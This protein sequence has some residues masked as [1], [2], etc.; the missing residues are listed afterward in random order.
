MRRRTFFIMFVAAVLAAVVFVSTGSAA[1]PPPTIVTGQDAGWPDVRGW[2]ALGGA[3]RQFAPWGEWP[4]AFSP[5][6]TYQQGIRV[7]VGDVNGDGHQEII[8]APGR[9][10]FTELRVFDGRTFDQVGSLLPFKD[11]A[12]WA[13]AYV[14][15]GDTNGDGRAEIVEGLDSGCC[16]TL[17][18]LDGKSGDDLSGF[19]PYGDR[20]E[21]G[22][23]VASGDV[24]GDGKTELFAVAY[25]VTV[26]LTDGRGRTSIARSMA[27]VVRKR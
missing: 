16:T 14:A 13:G 23:R 22:A 7:A 8:T 6:A 27:I 25:A 24:N 5:Y 11:G 19:F 10:A 21:V 2:N 9:N 12:W 3:A 1:P 17:H 15:T 4:L 20:S 18:V 26:T